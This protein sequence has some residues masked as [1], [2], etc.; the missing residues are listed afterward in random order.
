MGCGKAANYKLAEQGAGFLEQHQA[1]CLMDIHTMPAIA[2]MFALPKMRKYSQR[3]VLVETAETLAAFPVQP[4]R[5]D[6][7]GTDAGGAHQE[8][9]L[10]DPPHETIT[11]FLN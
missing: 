8:N 1:V 3:I 6:R 5:V 2:R 9:Q 11:E 10:L 7:A 4:D